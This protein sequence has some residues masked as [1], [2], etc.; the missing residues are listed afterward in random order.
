[1]LTSCEKKS[2]SFYLL[3]SLLPNPWGKAQTAHDVSD[4]L[5]ASQ[6]VMDPPMPPTDPS[7]A[8]NQKVTS[9][10]GRAKSV[11]EFRRVNMFSC[12]HLLLCS[13]QHF[14]T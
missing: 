2:L 3:H 8:N 7:Q 11:G 5:A 13:E 14:A 1:M 10:Y 4:V 9:A 6:R 12:L